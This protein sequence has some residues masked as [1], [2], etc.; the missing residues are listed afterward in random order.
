MKKNYEKPMVNRVNFSYE[1]QIV[2]ESGAG[3]KGQMN[4]NDNSDNCNWMVTNCVSP[5]Q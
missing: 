4:N 2:A 3:G 1:E 5:Y